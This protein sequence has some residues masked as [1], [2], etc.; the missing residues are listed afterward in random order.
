MCS[1]E[2]APEFGAIWRS[3]TLNITLNR[4]GS[5]TLRSDSTQWV[6]FI[7]TGEFGVGEDGWRKENSPEK[8]L[9]VDG[10]QHTDTFLSLRK[11]ISKCTV[12][13]VFSDYINLFVPAI[14]LNLGSC[15]F[16]IRH[17]TNRVSHFYESLIAA[18]MWKLDDEIKYWNINEARRRGLRRVK[19]FLSNYKM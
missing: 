17:L 7:D 6:R 9:S 5:R 3:C 4:T 18:V 13:Q 1:V 15:S 8:Q 19:T 12:F 2:F 14:L 16:M 11:A 10:S